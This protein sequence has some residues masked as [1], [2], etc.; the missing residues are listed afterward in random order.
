MN[1]DICS[2]LLFGSSPEAWGQ[3]V[4][5]LNAVRQKFQNDKISQRSLRTQR[6]IFL[7]LI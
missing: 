5:K 7:Q 1:T 4:A 6:D 2:P 3:V